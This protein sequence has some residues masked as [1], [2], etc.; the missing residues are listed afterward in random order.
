MENS[1]KF[2]KNKLCVDLIG[3]KKKNEKEA[4]VK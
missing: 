2:P 4:N 1:D 3:L